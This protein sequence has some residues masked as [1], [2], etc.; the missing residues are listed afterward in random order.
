MLWL[1]YETTMMMKDGDADDA[2]DDLMTSLMV[3]L[4]L[5]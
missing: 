2:H 1:S 5:M 4:K 3:M